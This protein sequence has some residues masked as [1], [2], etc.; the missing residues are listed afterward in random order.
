[1]KNEHR[2]YYRLTI[3]IFWFIVFNIDRV[4][5]FQIGQTTL[6]INE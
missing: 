1:L 6:N 3:S 4:E 5:Y 2:V